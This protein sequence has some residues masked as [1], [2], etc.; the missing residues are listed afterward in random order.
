MSEDIYT[1]AGEEFD[2][3]LD[4]D[5]PTLAALM[6]DA[7]RSRYRVWFRAGA[8]W[9]QFRLGGAALHEFYMSAGVTLGILLGITVTSDWFGDLPLSALWSG[10]LALV[11]TYYAPK[12]LVK[13]LRRFIDWGVDRATRPRS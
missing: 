6:D 2:R 11:A 8:V 12:I 3:R 9:A 10:I 4:G 5:T 13:A 7:T 1:E